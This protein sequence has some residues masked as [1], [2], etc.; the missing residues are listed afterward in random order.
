[1]VRRRTAMKRLWCWFMHR[2][3]W[4]VIIHDYGP[5]YMCSRCHKIWM[6]P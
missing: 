3:H 6:T 1:M 5:T 2:K 4:Y